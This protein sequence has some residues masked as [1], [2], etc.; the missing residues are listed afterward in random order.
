VRKRL[1]HFLDQIE[2]A[3]PQADFG[4]LYQKSIHERFDTMDKDE[5][6]N[7]LIWL[8]L[9]ETMKDYAQ[10]PDLNVKYTPGKNQSAADRRG[11][12]VRLFMNV[13]TKD[14]AS[15][16]RLLQFIAD[17]TDVDR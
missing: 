17:M 5:L 8:Q 13:G 12:S 3:Q 2:Q 14:G 9:K 7:R 1:F 4:D 6:I 10:A 11:G 16:A 15:E